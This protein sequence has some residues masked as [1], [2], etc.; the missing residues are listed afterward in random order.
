MSAFVNK[1]WPPTENWKLSVLWALAFG[2]VLSI[3]VPIVLAATPFRQYA[4]LAL[5]P[6][7]YPIIWAT[8]GWFV[9]ITPLG[10]V[11]MLSINDLAY[12]LPFVVAFRMYARRHRNA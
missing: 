9:G 1:V 12:A 7:L 6:G 4:W 3:G 5:F 8:G 10:Y 11:L 2:L